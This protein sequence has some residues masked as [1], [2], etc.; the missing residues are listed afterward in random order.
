VIPYLE[1]VARKK[2]KAKFCTV[3][4]NLAFDFSGPGYLIMWVIRHQVASA[5]SATKRLTIIKHLKIREIQS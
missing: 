3:D 4:Q 2:A 1:G 5:G